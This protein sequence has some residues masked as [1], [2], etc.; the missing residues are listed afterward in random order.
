MDTTF[1][2]VQEASH[3]WIAEGKTFKNQI[4]NWLDIIY[5]DEKQPETE[6]PEETR[7]DMAS[8]VLNQIVEHNRQGA[9]PALRELF[10]PD[11]DP[12]NWQGITECVSQVAFLPDN[13]LAIVVG[14]WYQNRA[15][16]LASGDIV[17]FQ[18]DIFMFGKSADK[19]YYAKAYADR[20]DVT[21]GW[22]GPV[23]RTFHPPASYGALFKEKFPQAKDG[24]AKLNLL[25]L[26]IHHIVVFPSGDR[27]ALASAKGIFILDS[28][29]AQF[30]QTEKYDE[31]EEEDDFTFS[32]H[33]PHIDVSPDG[34]YIAA[35]SQ[36]SAHLIFEETNGVW[37][38]IATVEPR[39]SYPNLARFNDKI[40]HVDDFEN[41]GPQL[42][43]CSC[44]F[45]RS[46]SI[47]LPIDRITPGFSASGY[48]ADDTLNYVD[49]KKWVF[50]VG[51]Y[52]W[53]YALGCNDGYIWFRNFGGFQF[54]YLHVGGTVMD[55]DYSADRKQMVVA[56]YSGQV[57]I[58]DC[59]DTI[60]P[61]NTLFRSEKNREEIRPDEFAITNT[62]YKDIK[63]YLFWKGYE[64]LVW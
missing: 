38:E 15:V 51:T 8:Y 3:R 36:S 53:G 57:V 43:L 30:I 58:Y 4:N 40:A 64:P 50:S 27:L 22:D 7:K 29:G 16:F 48:D 61:G 14:E 59:G 17:T 28:T 19:K 34:K 25:E 60:F 5:L 13:R 2:T 39:S 35:G 49:D 26:Q 52:K 45:S 20:I 37:T 32:L 54:G 63:R 47:A 18:E 23:L 1:K 6:C 24:L 55:I 42:L 41:S 10:P 31:T 11:N 62:C 21:E 33:Y 46:A 44:H 12:M 9:I 56:S